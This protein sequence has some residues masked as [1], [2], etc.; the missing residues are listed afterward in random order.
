M[1]KLMKNL[2]FSM[3]FVLFFSANCFTVKADTN[4]EAINI[5]N[6]ILTKSE[7]K[8]GSKCVYTIFDINNDGIVELIIVDERDEI[9]EYPSVVYYYNKKDKKTTQQVL[10]SKI[11]EVGEGA[12][13]TGFT[14][15]GLS[16]ETVY[17][18]EGNEITQIGGSLIVDEENF[19]YTMEDE[20]T[21]DE[22]EYMKKKYN[23]RKQRFYSVDNGMIRS[24]EDYC[25]TP[26]GLEYYSLEGFLSYNNGE[27]KLNV[28]DAS[29]DRVK[30]MTFKVNKKIETIY[31]YEYYPSRGKDINVKKFVKLMK[32]TKKG[33]IHRKRKSDGYKWEAALGIYVEDGVI[34]CV[35]E[36][37]V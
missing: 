35:E 19:Y 30:M 36:I 34:V 29:N 1:K 14:L 37:D 3:A 15:D 23:L 26:W 6:S 25:G 22:Y 13:C 7:W 32:K 5:F 21:K 8:S 27:I 31:R 24:V 2:L 18:C 12:I 9:I 33:K 28:S 17:S 11:T 4:D 10:D 16:L 20:I